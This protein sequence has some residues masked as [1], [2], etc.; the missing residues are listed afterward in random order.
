MNG[1]SPR[2]ARKEVIT[3]FSELIA[4]PI[5]D[6]TPKARKAMDCIPTLLFM[7]REVL[8]CFLNLRSLFATRG[9]LFTI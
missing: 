4:I 6:I 1:M 7:F 8:S 5:A 9:F 3:Y 2:E